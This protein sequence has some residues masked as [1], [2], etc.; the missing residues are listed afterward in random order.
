ME[1]TGHKPYTGQ[2]IRNYN[3]RTALIRSVEN[4]SYYADKWLIDG[5]AYTL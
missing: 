1:A 2:G 5:I 3:N 4:T